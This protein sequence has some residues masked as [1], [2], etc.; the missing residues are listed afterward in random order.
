MGKKRQLML[1]A[2]A[3][4]FLLAGCGGTQST[5][6]GATTPSGDTGKTAKT[7][8]PNSKTEQP[9]APV[10][11][12]VQFIPAYDQIFEKFVEPVMKQKLPYITLEHLPQ[13]PKIADLVATGV[14]PDITQPNSTLTDVI[15]LQ[16]P[17][18]LTALV[19]KTNFD[20]KRID[21]VLIEN[22][23]AYSTKNELL[24]LPSD[25]SS[26]V[27]MYNKD[28][29]DKF[30][31]PYPKDN[32]SWDDAIDLTR[33]ISRTDAGVQYHGLHPNNTRFLRSELGLRFFDANGKAVVTSAE[34]QK[35][36][37]V[38]KAI[39]D[40]PGNSAKGAIRDLFTK[41]KTMGMILSNASFLIRDPIPGFNW[42]LVTTPAF[43][44]K[45]T[46]D[47]LG[48]MFSISRSSKNADAAFEVLNLY[49]SDEVQS[50]IERDAYVVTTLVNPE[51]QK[52]F[53]V[54]IAGSS[55]L[56]LA[57]NFKGNPATKIVDVNE[58][59]GN[60]SINAAF[61]DIAEGNKDIN[62]ALRDAAKDMEQQLAEKKAQ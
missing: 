28:L 24:A 43:D 50:A 57:A 49:Y 39:Y 38:W 35:A 1:A 5:G 2:V 45:K 62:T 4:L 11:L 10:T 32:M 29:F 21:P 53:G 8:Q 47:Q 25:R 19:K 23:R 15:D 44:N 40:V 9:K 22:I 33:K 46:P 30:A 55:K 13:N 58:D 34:W 59:I 20:L 26:V 37:G 3:S 56:N 17:M 51:V 42:D 14:I 18:D 6:T 48:A 61:N 12:K 41:D 27:L 60:K 7:E 36:A 52:Q 31:V 16:L 54:N